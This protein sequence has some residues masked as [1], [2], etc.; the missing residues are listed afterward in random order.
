MHHIQGTHDLPLVAL[1]LLF[2]FL[3]SLTA[4]D[5]TRRTSLSTG[6][7]KKLW[8][9]SG[10]VAMGIG[11]WTMHFIAM[12]AFTLPVSIHYDIY[13]ALVSI[14]VA[15]AAS[16]CGLYVSC[17]SKTTIMNVV[18]GGCFMG[19]GIIGMHYIGMASMEGIH[20]V[21]SPILVLF[22]I[23]IAV[24]A[25]I[26]ALML[27]FRFRGSHNGVSSDAKLLSALVMGVAISST[28][29]TGML[30]TT[31]M[32][33]TK[34]L[35][36]IAATLDT[37]AIAS[38]VTIGAIAILSIV[39]AISFVLERK[40]DEEI[41]FKG[42]IL[43]SVLDCLI[44]IDHKGHMVECN[45]ATISTFGYTEGEL[46]GQSLEK[47][48][49]VHSS[50]KSTEISRLMDLDGE[51]IC[52]QRLEAA[53]V[54]SC[55]E[56]FPVELTITKI[57]KDGL[58]LFTVY[59]RDITKVKQSEAI[60]KK[61]AYRDFLTG[62]PNRRMF[63]EYLQKSLL[64]AEVQQTKV[65]VLFL[66]LDRFKLINDSM[67]HAFGD[68]LLKKVAERL[69]NC[70]GAENVVARN[71]GDEFTIILKE[72]THQ[73][74]ENIVGGIIESLKQPFILEKHEVFITTSIGIAM[75]PT[76]G[77]D[78]ETLV[79]NADIAMYEAKERGRNNYSFF[80][81]G[82][83]L[84]V[85]QKLQ[86]VNELRTALE[87]D[88]F[89]V[90]YQPRLH[91]DSGQIIGVEALVRWI[92]PEKGIISPDQFIPQ[93]EESGLIV[94]IGNWVLRTAVAQCKKW[95]DQSLPLEM[96]VNLSAVQFQSPNLVKMVS[97][98]LQSEGL[99]PKLLNLE[100][101]ENMMM[102]AEYSIQVLWELK[103]LGVQISI[104]DFGTGYNSLSYLKK[105]PIDHIKVDRSFMQNVTTDSENAAIVKAVISIAQSL[106]LNIIAEGVEDEEQLAFLKN[107]NCNE[108]QGYLLSPPVPAAKLESL[109]AN[110]SS[111]FV[112][113]GI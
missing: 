113:Q 100:I 21:Y 99:N 92:H 76:D 2:A 53:G 70:L 80:R 74:A 63:N 39:F 10:S 8:L 59:A 23:V 26:I 49:L 107:L 82:T 61:M 31:F 35:G 78:Q 43:E 4:I 105:M 62:L 103:N 34:S 24:G 66:D 47:R 19:L 83:D 41:I 93:A 46:I 14:V 77:E 90:Y 48:L 112:A 87:R 73:A 33:D 104:D 42:A 51:I 86:M 56:K 37:G 44:I 58:P 22:S 17:K 108:I 30:A 75:Y 68:L 13:L 52:N 60:I 9:V 71:G 102:D 55:G 28:H 111:F 69:Q 96:S 65:A 64:E 106:H 15:I 101:T 54:R 50:P 7:K 29:Y 45:P 38:G 97:E 81:A 3:A 1:S 5:T 67:G 16:F 84:Q 57:K 72:T 98:T 88:E 91:I 25:S 95:Q 40:L 27:A 18:I 79:K 20:I 12:L 110:H 94:P 11:I 36:K 6:W 85:V 89:A 32:Q 109:V